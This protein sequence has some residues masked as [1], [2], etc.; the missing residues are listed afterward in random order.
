MAGALPL[1]LRRTP[2]RR[3]QHGAEEDYRTPAAASQRKSSRFTAARKSVTKTTPRRVG[4]TAKSKTRVSDA[5]SAAGTDDTIDDSITLVDDADDSITVLDFDIPIASKA[6]ATGHTTPSG[7]GKRKRRP[8]VTS[9]S[10]SSGNS[11]IKRARR[12]HGSDKGSSSTNNSGNTSIVHVLPLRTQILDDHIK[13]RIRRNGLSAE[14]NSA[15]GEKRV[16]RNKTLAELRRARDDLRSRDA[17]IERLRELTAIFDGGNHDEDDHDASH[18]QDLERELARLREEV[19]ARQHEDIPSSSPPVRDED[20]DLPGGMS[21][22]GFDDEFG[23]SSVAELES[24]G[25]PVHNHHQALPGR[26][27]PA[28]LH[29]HGPT[30]TPP[31]TSPAKLP[32]SPMRQIHS[33][34]SP[35]ASTRTSSGCD[36]GVQA[37]IV[38][39]D[40]GLQVWMSDPGMDALQDDLSNLRSEM[41]S[42]N[43]AFVERD[44]LQARIKEKLVQHQLPSSTPSHD[45]TGED[46]DV[47]LQLDIILQDLTEKTTRLAEL[48]SLLFSPPTNSTTTNIDEKEMTAELTSAIQSVHQALEDLNPAS[49]LPQSTIDT[50]VLAASRLN[51]LDTK[52]KHRTAELETSREAEAT[53]RAQLS[54]REAALAT[55]DARVTNLERDVSHLHL[56]IES[57]RDE[58]AE[59][60]DTTTTLHADLDGARDNA[61]QQDAAVAEAEARLA[62]A[63]KQL[64]SLGEQL[65]ERETALRGREG[66][67]GALRVDVGRLEA[68]LAEARGTVDALRESKRK[69]HEAAKSAVGAMR[70]QMLRALAVGDGFLGVEGGVV[71][72]EEERECV[73][74]SEEAARGRRGDSGLGLSEEEEGP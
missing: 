15:Y 3:H 40:A 28:A 47:E 68:A 54:H 24:G 39:A 2:R 71:A 63:L 31:S 29:L 44:S 4:D 52:L 9:S 69:E 42:L 26:K 21:D 48:S 7:M 65:T 38:S 59:L 19:M 57:L 62:D 1:A 43:E 60:Q 61:L 56:T 8:S 36:A 51:E 18:V 70:A 53:L 49:A 5:A 74:G 55:K 37:G 12:Q 30:L 66:E 58:V 13:R 23:D 6:S 72:K 25:T 32:S 67:V 20:W 27:K 17:E 22:H 10:P 14:M 41:A 46:Q 64:A 73:V 45:H 50:L 33:S 11:A 34:G 35:L 16:R